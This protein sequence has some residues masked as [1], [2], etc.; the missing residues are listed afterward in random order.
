MDVKIIFLNRVVGE[1]IYIE[2][3]EGFEAHA[4]DS[5]ICKIKRALYGLKKA[6]RTWYSCINNY[7][8]S[9]GFIKS[10]VDSKLYYV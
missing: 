3:P 8:Q 7:L 5:H 6:P 1:E 4:R 2:K 10:E 9:V